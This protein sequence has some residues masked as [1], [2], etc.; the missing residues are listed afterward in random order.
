TDG[1]IF[2]RSL[3]ISVKNLFEKTTHF[4]KASFFSTSNMVVGAFEYAYYESAGTNYF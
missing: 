3:D 2:S 1:I 4:E